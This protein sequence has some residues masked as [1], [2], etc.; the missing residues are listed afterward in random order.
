MPAQL[1]AHQGPSPITHAAS[2]LQS[3]PRP[4]S[5]GGSS[6]PQNTGV[7][8]GQSAPYRQQPPQPGY[9]AQPTP[10]TPSTEQHGA[11]GPGLQGLNNQM[12]HMSLG[13]SIPPQD[14]QQPQEQQM[15]QTGPPRAGSEVCASWSRN[16]TNDR[17]KKA[18]LPS[19]PGQ[20]SLPFAT[21]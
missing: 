17:C 2:Q 10:P 20:S 6:F 8:T 13:G 9:Q 4:P 14:H 1:Q 5:M 16:H 15:P 18:I 11:G 19:N 3:P 21:L 7:P 12:S